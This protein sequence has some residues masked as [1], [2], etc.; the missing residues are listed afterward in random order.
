MNKNQELFNA[1]NI[2]IL[3]KEY[4]NTIDEFLIK[5]LKNEIPNAVYQTYKIIDKNEIVIFLA[6]N[7][8]LKMIRVPIVEEEKNNTQQPYLYEYSVNI[9]KKYNPN[10]GSSRVCKCGHDYHRHFDSYEENNACGCKYCQCYDFVE[11][12]TTQ[13][14]KDYISYIKMLTEN[15]LSVFNKT[16]KELKTIAK[17]NNLSLEEWKRTGTFDIFTNKK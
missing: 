11:D 14:E 4:T 16:L 10:Y 1:I 7:N 2:C 9:E 15:N 17:N 12:T 5:Y 8:I 13:E 3:N 6:I